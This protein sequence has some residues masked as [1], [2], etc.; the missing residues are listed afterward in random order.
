MA[1]HSL[2]SMTA[3]ELS[4]I[5]DEELM[6]RHMR[7][8]KAS[9]VPISEFTRRNTKE[10][11]DNTGAIKD[12]NRKSSFLAWGMIFLAVVSIIIAILKQ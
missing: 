10:I 4:N 7:E 8:D 5:S 2:A 9:N 11:K 6:Q 3:Q 12:F 1:A